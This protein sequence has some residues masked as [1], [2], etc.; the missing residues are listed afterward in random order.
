MAPST[1]AVVFVIL[2]H[3][4][5]HCPF[6]SWYS[7]PQNGQMEPLLVTV[8]FL[9]LQTVSS[10]PKDTNAMAFRPAQRLFFYCGYVLSQAGGDGGGTGIGRIEVDSESHTLF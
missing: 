9:A 8:F 3:G 10:L 2:D 1:K 4:R 5:Q 6:P 7:L